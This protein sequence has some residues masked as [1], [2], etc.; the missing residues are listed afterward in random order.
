VTCVWRPGWP[1]G[2]LQRSPRPA[3][4]NRGSGPTSNRKEE[5]R[6]GRGESGEEGSVTG[7]DCLLLI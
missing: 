1:L 2:E 6:K 5:E 4:R 3:S 7:G